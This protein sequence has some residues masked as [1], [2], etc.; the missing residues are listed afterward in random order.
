MMSVLLQLS[1]CF[2]VV[3]QLTSTQLTYE[4][5]PQENDTSGCA[6]TREML[7]QLATV[8]SQLQMQMRRG[9]S[10]LR[11][12][13]TQQLSKLQADVDEL[14]TGKRRSNS[15]GGRI[16]LHSLFYSTIRYVSFIE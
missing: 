7:S 14:K 9:F 2:V 4:V 15:T 6:S 3:I 16:F 1:L 5:I 8:V 12:E 11:K 10:Q 13:M